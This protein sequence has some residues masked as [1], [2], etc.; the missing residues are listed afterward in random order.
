VL[1]SP[2]TLGS[3]KRY[4]SV[5]GSCPP[6]PRSPKG[7]LSYAESFGKVFS[8]VVSSSVDHFP[9]FSAAMEK[10]PRNIEVLK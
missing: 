5:L 8:A 9:P 10:Y 6:Q 3:L 7:G 1:I 4:L 2:D